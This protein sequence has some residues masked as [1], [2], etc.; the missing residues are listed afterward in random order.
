MKGSFVVTDQSGGVLVLIALLLVVIIGMAAIALDVGHLMVVRN[1]LRNAADAGALAGAAK[2]YTTNDAGELVINPDADFVASTTT[3]SNVS[4]AAAAEVITVERG[5]WCFTNCAGGA[6]G[7]FT[8]NSRTDLTMGSFAGLSYQELDGNTDYV[9]AVRVV[10]GRGPA[11]P[12]A[13]FFAGI[14]NFAGFTLSA[15][16]IA[17]RGFAGMDISVD[18]PL[19][20]CG[21]DV[22]DNGGNFTCSRGRMINSSSKQGYSSESGGWTNLEQPDTCGGA[23]PASQVQQLVGQGCSGALGAYTISSGL[24]LTTSGGEVQSAYTPLYNCWKG[25]A[26]LDTDIMN[27]EGIVTTPTDSIPDKPWSMTLPLI[28]CGGSNPGP[29]NKVIG[30][31]NVEVVWITNQNDPHFNKIPTRYKYSEPDISVDYTCPATCTPADGQTV[32]ASQETEAGRKLCW[33][34]F[35][36]ANHIVD[37]DGNAFTVDAAADGYLQKNIIFKPSCSA[38]TPVGAPGGV[39]GGV[40]SRIPWLVK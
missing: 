8:P 35:L 40:P 25:Q 27:D 23:A 37:Q 1:E 7:V 31:I 39:F 34:N 6:T 29:C 17:Y 9:N 22:I 14:W 4:D 11:I 38:A 15:E 32:C 13:S 12:A 3:S 5:H 26:S 16:S 24:P 33:A 28:E 36:M 2:L 21:E 10:A 19:A 30:A 18:F 20:I